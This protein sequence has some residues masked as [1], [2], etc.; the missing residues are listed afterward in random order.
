MLVFSLDGILH[1]VVG[2]FGR[3]MELACTSEASNAGASIA[4]GRSTHVGRVLS[5]VPDK[6]IA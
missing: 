3:L 1:F 6:E 2:I 4:A 5:E